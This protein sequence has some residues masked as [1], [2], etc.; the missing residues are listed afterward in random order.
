M[1]TIFAVDDSNL[2]LMMVEEA[3]EDCFRVMTM[4]SGAKMFSLLPRIVPDLI[5]LDI[6]MPEMD[7]FEVLQKL[8]AH[9]LYSS[10]PVV[11]LTAWSD[12]PTEVRGFELGAAD[13][14]TKPFS[15]PV[16]L[17]RVRSHL[18]VDELIR[19]RT[20][21]LERLKNGVI[22]VLADMVESRDL[23]TGGHIERTAAY[24]KILVDAMTAR[25]LHTE[26]VRG[27]DVE[28]VVSS[29]RLHD[30]GKIAVSD[31]ILGKPGKLTAEEFE[32]IKVHTT[33]GE[34]IINQIVDRTGE[35]A[36]LRHAKLFAGY[37][38]ERW[39]GSGYPYK[40]QKEDIP[41]HGRMMAIA[42]VYD[43]LV[44]E[45]PYKEAYSPETAER[46]IMSD[47]GKHFDPELA[48][49]FYAVRDQFKAVL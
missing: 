15:P 25:G 27:W 41:L 45:R 14:I 32:K 44:S 11:L 3:L 38:H 28:M 7:G 8:K 34:R 5:L 18:N 21:Q 46:I 30:V 43:A 42:D 23:T 33:E 29:A 2:N 35:E 9:E 31:L 20:S 48:E 47:A 13:F 6:E 24:I 22:S 17:N 19:E 37:H 26:E 1:K 49:T 10:I 12:A 39:D 4:L 16:L 40:L 36:F